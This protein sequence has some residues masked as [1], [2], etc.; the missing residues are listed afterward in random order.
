[1]RTFSCGWLALVVAL[2]LEVPALADTVE[3]SSLLTEFSIR[4][5]TRRDGLPS[6]RVWAITQDQT[7]YLWLGT[8]SGLIRFDGVRFVTWERINSTRLPDTSV[9]GLMSASDGSLWVA[10]SNNGIARIHGGTITAYGENEGL[11]QGFMKTFAEDRQGHI[12]AGGHGGLFRFTGERWE[13]QGASAGLPEGPNYGVYLDPS[14]V[15]WVLTP[16]GVYRK[17]GSDSRFERSTP[18]DA[19]ATPESSGTGSVVARNR[20]ARPFSATS[21]IHAPSDPDRQRAQPAHRDRR[22]TRVSLVSDARP[23]SMARC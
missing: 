2:L 4:S 14:D 7:G 13:H 19:L 9:L 10:F 8:A 11:P 15:L 3:P 6:S 12:W 23:G 18:F 1:M 21:A 20:S 16:S 5:W 22:S 17:S